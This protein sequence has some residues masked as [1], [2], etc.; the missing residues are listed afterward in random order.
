[1]HDYSG[2]KEKAVNVT[3]LQLDPKN[4]RIPELGHEG[5]QRE[6]VAELVQHDNVYELARDIA[7]QGYFPTEVLI[8]VVENGANI[9]VEGNRRLAAVKLLL[10]PDLAPEDRIKRFRLLQGKV[11]PDSL[12][13]V[14]VIVAP[15]REAAAPL[16]VN[17]HTGTGVERWKPAQQA[18]YFRTFTEGGMSIEDVAA[19]LGVKQGELRDNL[20]TDTMYRIACTLDLPKE[21][22]EKVR[23]PRTFNASA[24]E[25]LVQ[26]SKVTDFLGV[27]FD[28]RGRAIGNIQ[29]QEFKKAYGKMVTDIVDGKAD[30]RTLH[31]SEKIE[32]YLNG[33]GSDAPN[34]K[35]R[36]SFTSDS[37]LGTAAPP[38]ARSPAGSGRGGSATRRES[39]YLIPPDVKCRL[40]NPRIND[41]F[42]ELRRLKVAE[43]ENACAILLRI[44]LELAVGYYL[45]RTK[46]IQPL[47]DK[48]QKQGKGSD[49]YPT[50]RQMLSAVLAEKSEIPT[51]ARKALN[52]M[53]SDNDHP[54]SLD[55]ID[56][57][58]H[59][60]YVAPSE[61]ELRKLWHMLEDFMKQMLQ[62]PPAPPKPAK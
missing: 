1:M 11:S 15:S 14:R 40:K 47:L 5:T 59:N 32:N 41:I 9:V 54:L 57:F 39:P 16:I 19:H 18:R 58:A 20:R 17:R 12:R 46:K 50:L 7:D 61:K 35:R 55:K 13:Q 27:K 3:S 33:F 28:E 30:T 23:N 26:S 44:L 52:K 53:V 38:T 43:F 31:D 4:P 48:A 10:S 8:A 34:R 21:T 24:L 22:A 2:W 42:R 29:P 6:I 25:R 49:W 62:E 37:L 51:L 56:Q 45:D 60:R 36:G